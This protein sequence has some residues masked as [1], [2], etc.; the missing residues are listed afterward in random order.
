M[1]RL[2][3]ALSCLLGAPAVLADAQLQY[4][5]ENDQS[6]AMRIEVGGDLLRMEMPGQDGAVLINPGRREVLVLDDAKRR[7]TRLDPATVA[8]LGGQMAA[9]R[10]QMQSAMA[11]M[12]PQQ[13][14]QIEQMMGGN[15]AAMLGGPSP[16][17]TPAPT[18]ERTGDQKRYGGF[19]CETAH[20]TTPQGARGELCIAPAVTLGL[21]VTDRAAFDAAFA[22][23]Q[24]LAEPLRAQGLGAW[25]DAN[26][27]PKGFLLV[28]SAMPDE[29]AQRLAKVTRDAADPARFAV[30][31]DYTAQE[32]PGGL[33]PMQ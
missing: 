4:V 28:R 30:P 23:A 8:R 9:V 13:R 17:A 1:R 33:P 31:A 7:Y 29:P 27:F 3:L 26:V 24:E 25:F 15:A 10:E 14:A 32:L 16:G 20:Y 18:F 6:P 11:G 2:I 19:D 12:S 22:F 5:H 21:G